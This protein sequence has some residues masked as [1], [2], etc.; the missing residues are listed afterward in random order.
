MR[1]C[2]STCPQARAVQ[3]QP[4][5]EPA[6]AAPL[7]F[8][9]TAEISTLPSKPSS[10]DRAGLADR[11]GA[12]MSIRH[13]SRALLPATGIASTRAA[14]GEV[15]EVIGLLVE[16]RGPGAAIGDFCE[17]RTSAGRTIR[18]QVIGFRDGRVLSMPLE[19]TDGIATRRSGRR[20]AQAGARAVGPG[21]LGRVLDGF[22]QP[23]DS[24][25][26]S[27]PRRSTICIS[28]PGS[29]LEREHITSRWSPA[30][31]PSTACFPA[32]R[33]SA[34]GFSAAAASARALCS[35][36]MSRHNS[37]DVSVIALIGERN[38][39]VRAFL[40]HELG[41]GGHEARRSWW[42]PPPTARRRCASAPASWRWPSPSIFAIRAP[43][44]CWS[45][46]R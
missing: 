20:R 23:I 38:R 3:L 13:R 46:I 33:A 24:G 18:T 6:N 5:P 19:E 15:I 2:C 27:R 10:G 44:C 43:T 34:S 8:E 28:A 30:F 35:A 39:E 45:W 36:S 16:S 40:E 32:E 14:T 29:P 42:W 31:A 17:I 9:T 37:A 41:P 1:L 7:I 11:L 25:A 12:R 21:L 22:G 26:P 4:D